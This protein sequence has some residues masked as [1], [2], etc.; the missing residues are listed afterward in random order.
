MEREE[1]IL[2]NM[3]I[4]AVERQNPECDNYTFKKKVWDKFELYREI[5]KETE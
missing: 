4:N 2:L 1:K 5:H 3:C